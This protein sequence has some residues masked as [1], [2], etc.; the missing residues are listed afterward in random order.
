MEKIR[1]VNLGGW[2][3]LERW[4]DE[5]LFSDNKIDGNDE[6]RFNQQA[7]NPGQLLNQHYETFITFDDLDWLKDQGV[8]V[9]RLPIPWWLFGNDVYHPSVTYIDKV[10]AYL[11]SIDL[12]FM[13]DL[14][15]APGCQ[16]GFDNGGIQGQLEW[17]N[18]PKNI[19]QTIEVLVAIANRYKKNKNF[20]SIQLLNEPFVTV[21]MD[22]IQDFYLRAYQALRH[23]LKDHYIVMHDGFRLQEWKEFF[24]KNDFH[25]VI[26]DTHMY[27]CFDDRMTGFTKEEHVKQ[28][29]KRKETLAKIEEFVPVVVGEWSLGLRPNDHIKDDMDQVMKEYASAQLQ[30]M[31]ECTGHIFWAYRVKKEKSGWHFRDLVERGIID[32]KEFLQ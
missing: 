21:D 31:R 14:H 30:A 11:E 7:D 5:A 19:D 8:N 27:Q 10:L 1:S 9:V 18:D 15:T 16:N 17:P 28:A 2:F 25:N 29:L 24:T 26:L 13:L 3:V 32:M 20:H 23:I 4:M 12:N 22:I 6:T